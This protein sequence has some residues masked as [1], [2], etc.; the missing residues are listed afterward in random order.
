V[1][2]PGHI[3][4]RYEGIEQGN[5]EATTH[6]GYIPDSQ[7]VKDMQISKTAITNGIYMKPLS[8]KEFL[9]TLLVNNAF[10][11]IEEKKDTANAIIYLNLA[12]KYDK[13]NM[14]ALNSLGYLLKDTALI[15]K[16]KKTGYKTS[17]Y[18]DEFYKKLKKSLQ[19]E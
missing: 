5:V 13:N 6:G 17:E 18:S 15:S 16:A 10:Y 1:R 2:G 19:I 9:S 12:F 14:E 4:I 11:C 7:Y 3:F 8:R